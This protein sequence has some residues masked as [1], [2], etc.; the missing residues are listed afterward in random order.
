MGDINNVFICES[1]DK[2]K[3]VLVTGANGYIG[4]YVV[5]QLLNLGCEV[6]ASDF[7]FDGVDERA[8]R[9]EYP[10]FSGETDI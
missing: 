9:V 1:E 2:M 3:T 5:K 4:R 10:I 7:S 8:K 6:L